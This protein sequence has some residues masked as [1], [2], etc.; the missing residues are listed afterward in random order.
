MLKVKVICPVL[1]QLIDVN[2]Q[3]C[4]LCEQA[5]NLNCFSKT[6]ST[7]IRF[8][9]FGFKMQESYDKQ[10]SRLSFIYKLLFRTTALKN[11]LML[12]KEVE[13]GRK[14]GGGNFGFQMANPK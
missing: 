2:H 6:M 13:R 5:Y 10:M 11:I 7:F 4:S 3:Q 9:S 12:S 14:G 8:Y 1:F